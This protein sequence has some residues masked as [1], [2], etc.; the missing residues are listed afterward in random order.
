MLDQEWQ[1]PVALIC[2]ILKEAEGRNQGNN[3]KETATRRKI[4]YAL[5]KINSKS[6]LFQ[7]DTEMKDRLK[8]D[9]VAHQE[10]AMDIDALMTEKDIKEMRKSS[11]HRRTSVQ[12]GTGWLNE[13]SSVNM[14]LLHQKVV[15]SQA[16]QSNYTHQSMSKESAHSHQ[17]VVETTNANIHLF[18]NAQNF[19]FNIFKFSKEIGRQHTLTYLTHHLL[20][21]LP[22]QPLKNLN[23]NEERLVNFLNTVTRGYQKDVEY[24]NDLHGA[25]VMQMTFMLLTKCGLTKIAELGP[26]DEMSLMVAAACHD[27][28]HDGMNNAYHVNAMTQRAVRYHDQ[29]VQ[30]NFHAAESMQILLQPDCNFF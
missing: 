30:E 19:E 5:D 6:S 2:S 25:D 17:T 14:N 11:F 7:V 4:K 26:L 24:H 3:P 10:D 29:S 13:Y 8:A 21:Q 16:S 9:F 1:T 20:T 22:S 27:F 12:I 18:E 28:N 23:C 15:E